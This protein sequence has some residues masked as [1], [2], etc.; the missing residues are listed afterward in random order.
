MRYS[1]L[2]QA[3]GLA[4]LSNLVV[5]EAMATTAHG[6]G[7]ED[8]ADKVALAGIGEYVITVENF[9]RA[10]TRYQRLARVTHWPRLQG[11]QLTRA[12]AK[13]G[14]IVQIRQRLAW[15]GDHHPLAPH[16]AV[17]T[18]YDAQLE[19]AVRRFQYRHGLKVDGV[20][21]PNTRRALS[22]H[23][24]QRLQ[25]LHLNQRRVQQFS[26]QLP[27]EYLQINIPS[28]HLSYVRKDRIALAMKAIVGRY[29]RPTPILNS[30]LNR[31]VI[32]PDW[33]VPRGIAYKD[34]VPALRTD[35]RTLHRKGLKLVEG[36][37]PEP[38]V[39]PVAAL[40]WQ[41]LYLGPPASLQRFWQPPGHDNPLGN[42]KFSFP[43]NY[44][45]FMH[46]TPELHLFDEPVRAFSSGCIRLE[47]PRQLA[48]LLIAG[49]ARWP[50]GRLDSLLSK[51]RTRHFH[52]PYQMPIYITYWTAWALDGEVF[53]RHD[54]YRRDVADY[55]RLEFS[56]PAAVRTGPQNVPVPVSGR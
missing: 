39:L 1:G 41:R 28:Y 18:F 24:R 14:E 37:H 10:I 38:K 6:S 44:T 48:E 43:N 54:I 52:L 7:D 23:P 35:K 34:I 27:L 16:E 26:Q 25:Q 30:A 5:F 33:N 51:Q 13:R 46:G 56:P 9:E 55:R 42:L 4:I 19:A 32:H 36:F 20:I 3:M 22:I 50:P 15:L 53:F 2:R 49:D 21:G 17:S 45:V 47:K 31:L 40:D 29:K 11:Q 12:G 8:S